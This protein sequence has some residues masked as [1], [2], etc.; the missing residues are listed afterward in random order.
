MPASIQLV[1]IDLD[2]TLLNSDGEVSDDNIEAIQAAR[3]QGV[4]V[5]VATGKSRGSAET[6][7]ERL[8]LDTPGV[9][10]Q[11]LAIFDADGT[12]IR[13]R[14]LDKELLKELLDDLKEKDLPTIAYA[15][16]R[17]LTGSDSEARQLLHDK[18]H[19]PLPE[20]L[21]DYEA[22]LGRGEF[23]VNKL[24]V[25]DLENRDNLRSEL[26]EKVGDRA[27]LTQAVPEYIEILPAD[28][29]KGDGVA[30]LLAQLELDP[31]Q[32][33]AIGD[34][35]NDLEMLRMAEIGVAMGN[36]DDTV[37]DS[38]EVVVATNDENG[39]AEAIRRFVLK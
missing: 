36:A 21:D 23:G 4:V 29:S 22:A 28:G 32:L 2:G 17:L 8:Q 1:A 19:E 26:E 6:I 25:S 27:G 30:W 24:I 18:F 34:G 3:Q 10:T 7:R 11:G 15:G 14:T 33:L 35:E 12:L 31:S 20:I 13:E 9:Y 5:I 16:Q 39:V 38:A 37:K